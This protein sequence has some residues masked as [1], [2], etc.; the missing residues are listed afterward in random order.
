MGEKRTVDFQGRKVPGEVIEYQT[1]GENWNQYTLADGS[2]VKMKIVLLEVV[3]LE[4]YN[5]QTGDPIYIFTAQQITANNI[6][7]NLKK[8]V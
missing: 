7:E 3:R 4:E 2:R 5:P 8:K 6:P 1:H